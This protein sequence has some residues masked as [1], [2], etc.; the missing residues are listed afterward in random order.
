MT[1]LDTTGAVQWSKNYGNY[2]DGVNQFT[3][4]GAGDWALIYNECWGIA[5]TYDTSGTSAV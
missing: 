3:D 2:P 5:P 1:K 4:S